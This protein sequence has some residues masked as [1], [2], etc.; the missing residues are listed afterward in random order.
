MNNQLN[1]TGGYTNGNEKTK[2]RK[3]QEM[4]SKHR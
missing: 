1:I 4:W 2:T 3:M